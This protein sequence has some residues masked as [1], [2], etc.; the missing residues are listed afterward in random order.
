MK[1]GGYSPFYKSYIEE[2]G[3]TKGVGH[4]S[5]MGAGQRAEIDA[6]D[7]LMAIAIRPQMAIQEQTVDGKSTQTAD[8]FSQASLSAMEAVKRAAAGKEI[9]G[10]FKPDEETQRYAQR[11]IASLKDFKTPD[12]AFT[13][14]TSRVS[15][16]VKKQAGRAWDPQPVESVS[17]PQQSTGGEVDS[18]LLGTPE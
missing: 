10:G 2:T 12:E 11:A 15:P 13:A 14:F 17:A 4:S 8:D 18:L 5:E 9:A 1:R 3:D 7:N 6:I 16:D